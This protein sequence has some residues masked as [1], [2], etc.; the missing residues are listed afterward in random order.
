MTD[1]GKQDLASPR[2]RACQAADGK[3][4]RD[5][6]RA[7]R[8]DVQGDRTDGHAERDRALFDGIAESYCAKDLAGASRVARRQ[9]LLR[10]V[11]A[12]SGKRVLEAGCG[13]GFSAQYLRGTFGEFVGVD[14]SQRLIDYAR[15]HNSGP[16]V[17][18]E[19]ADLSVWQ[20]DEPFDVVF[21]IGVLHHVE[22]LPAVMT[23][24]VRLLKP[25]GWLVANEPHPAN[26]LI[27]LARRIRKRI[28]KTY[29]DEQLQMS[30]QQLRTAYE[31][32]G[33]TDIRIRPQGLLSTPLA[34]VVMGPQWLTRPIARAA[35][36]ID[37]AIEATLGGTARALT[38]NL[39]AAG[40]K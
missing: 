4:H 21:L 17:R 31:Q 10:T 26:P 16:G 8:H 7:D 29:S 20:P 1:L 38:W 14:Y 27:R 15:Q 18:F 28:D 3:A 23:S 33:L 37:T 19:V 6:G 32:A 36:G 34:E 35:S 12:L 24:L 5:D 13:A 30:A 40:R 2:D 11:A 22:D 25:G 39:V 9:R